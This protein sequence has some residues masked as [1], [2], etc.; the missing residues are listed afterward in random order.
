M[1]K[2]VWN[3]RSVEEI[4]NIVNNLGYSMLREYMV[5]K[6]RRVVIQDEDGYRYDVNLSDL[7]DNHTPKFVGNNN[8]FTLPNISLWIKKE[9][10]P[11]VLCENNIY[12][13][14]ESKLF[15][16]CLKE[17]CQEIF[18]MSWHHVYSGHECSFCASKRVGKRN[19]LAYL[20]PD[21]V[22]EWD[23]NKNEKS[24]E[25]YTEFANKK[26]FWICS[27]CESSWEST[28]INRSNGSG[29][30]IC[31]QRK[32]EKKIGTWLANNQERLMDIGFINAPITQKRF[33]NCRNKNT[34]PFDF[35]LEKFNG[36]WVLIEYHGG[37][38]FF[39]VDFFG[40]KEK[41]KTQKKNDK[42]KEKYCENNNIQLLVISYLNFDKI[43]EILESYFFNI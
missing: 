1:K 37:Q 23:Y 4:Q 31:N 17:S 11:F 43:E 24:P 28:I 38:H 12:N 22:K 2:I 21:L 29:C 20:R 34:L 40:G 7:M 26:V 27:S 14:S 3:M 8:P 18:D 41:F 10:K 16:Q 39:P 42:I 30:P 9:N 5:G 15:F 25:E 13:G 35:G 19:N 33:V 6:R 36:D 32:G